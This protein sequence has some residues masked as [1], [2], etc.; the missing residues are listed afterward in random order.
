LCVRHRA[1]IVSL[2]PLSLSLS[3]SRALCIL[4]PP[5]ISGHCWP[6]DFACLLAL[7]GIFPNA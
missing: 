7:H 6:R 3:R 2:L 4:A 1:I 5:C